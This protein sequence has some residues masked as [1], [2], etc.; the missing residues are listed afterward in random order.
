M[1]CKGRQY[2]LNLR[3]EQ[4]EIPDIIFQQPEG[5]GIINCA[6]PVYNNIPESSH[7]MNLFQHYRSDDA[8][9]NTMHKNIFIVTG[10]SKGEI[11]VQDGTNIENIFNCKFDPLIDPVL[12]K[13][14]IAEFFRTFW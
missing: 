4:E 10:N 7:S 1:F 3:F 14:K 12:D 11:C 2:C 5:T 6:V 8:F 13:T 9:I